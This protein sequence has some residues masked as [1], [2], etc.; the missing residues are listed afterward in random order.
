MDAPL[1]E[2][3]DWGNF[4]D[5]KGRGAFQECPRGRRAIWQFRSLCISKAVM[6]PINQSPIP[7]NT[8]EN[9]TRSY[10]QVLL[11]ALGC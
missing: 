5:A 6:I 9:Q 4:G 11:T 2:E 10:G 1:R 8:F 3:E 7:K